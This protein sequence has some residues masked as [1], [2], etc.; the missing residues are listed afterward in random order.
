MQNIPKKFIA[1]VVVIAFAFG[2]LGGLITSRYFFDKF[3]KQQQAGQT[4]IKQITEEK[5]YVEESDAI[6]AIKKVSPSVVSIVL[7]KDVKIY[8]SMPFPFISPFG[9]DEFFNEFFGQQFGPS[10]GGKPEIKRQKVGGGTGFIVTADGLVVTNKHVVS[11]EDAEYT[12]IMNDGVEY[13][14][15][16]IS[17][18]PMNDLAVIKITQKNG[19][20][21]KIKT[22][23]ALEFG[24]SDS[25]Q[26]GQSI[27]AIGYALGEYQNTV[28]KGIISAKGRE[29]TAGG[30][31]GV[32]TLSGLIQTDA[33]INSGNSGGPLIN[34]KGQVIGVNVA[35]AANAQGIGFAIPVN[36]LK[37]VLESIQK[38]GKI[39][40]PM[41]GVRYLM[42]T[43]EKADELKIK[44]DSGALLVGEDE[45][46]KF[47][48]VP[49]SA[50]DK[51]GLRKG[52]VILEV[53]SKKIG[54]DYTLQQ[55]IRDKKPGDT[56][57][58]KVWRSGETF[59]KNVKL[60]ESKDGAGDK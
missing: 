4:V 51:T 17:Q 37:P 6:S 54:L 11:D 46:G 14:A 42:L 45:K 32:A 15:K 24:D 38:Y 36:D 58:L 25:V 16:V 41:L 50:A 22:F 48:V 34:L 28:T 13:G 52:D 31:E 3:V 53:D 2:L 23:P 40:R 44:V 27:L 43:P 1:L 35:M 59:E 39:V 49:G 19:D 47:A 33:S 8:K 57:K 30:P 26:I 9:N 29:I 10:S 55:S 60:E 12:I 18:D 56:I 5:T 21:A 7:T 20:S